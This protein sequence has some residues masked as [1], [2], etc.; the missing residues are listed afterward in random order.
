MWILAS[1]RGGI[2]HSQKFAS[3]FRFGNRVLH[4]DAAVR[5]PQHLSL[6][7]DPAG[8]R[9]RGAE[10]AGLENWR[11]VL[12]CWVH[13]SQARKEE[14]GPFCHWRLR[15][16]DTKFI[17]FSKEAWQWST[18][19]SGSRRHVFTLQETVTSLPRGLDQESRTISIVI[20]LVIQEFKHV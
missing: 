17:L 15:K 9:E 16:D 6:G 7:S 4:A 12:E 11:S 20:T 18:L 19:G 5:A 1:H 2:E 14:V 8:S 10:I 3:K 13:F